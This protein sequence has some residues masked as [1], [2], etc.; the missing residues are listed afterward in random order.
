[1]AQQ[2]PAFRGTFGSTEFYLITM[3]AG[4]MIRNL[5]VPKD[6]E[7]WEDLSPEERFQR[8]VNYRRVARHIA[9]Y[10]AEDDDRFIGAFIV[11]AYQDE[12]MEFESLVTAGA[13]FPKGMPN[14]LM[15]QF[16]VLYLSGSEVLVPLDGQHRL[17]ALKFAIEGRD[18]TGKDIPL[19]EANPKV[20]DDTCT[21]ILIRHEPQKARKIFNKVN[22]YAKPT[23]KSDNLIT[24]DDDYIAVISR[25]IVAGDLIE[26]RLVNIRSNTLPAP[27]GQFTTLGTIYEICLGYEELLTQKKVD[28]NRLPS[29]ADVNLARRNTK[30]FW[31]AFLEIEPYRAS[32]MNAREDG[33][34]R[35]S[36]IRGQSVACRPIAQRALAEASFLL[37]SDEKPDGSKFGLA[38]VVERINQVDWSPAEPVWQGILMNGDKVITGNGAM[39]FAARVVAY[40]LGQNLESVEVRKLTEQFASNTDGKELP[41][42]MFTP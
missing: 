16:G 41:E 24:A 12:Q 6:M 39:K 26:T 23:T 31:E 9:P 14:S 40:L 11:A 20:A 38:E 17:A 30:E 10:L 22:R 36:E 7:G 18:N 27:S 42:K 32:L 35:R 3:R 34:E 8:D 13:K 5:T 25:E 15:E 33:D 19:F 1:M 4:E 29:Q 2:L 37:L 28:T 21:I